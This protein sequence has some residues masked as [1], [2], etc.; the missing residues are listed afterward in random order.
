VA[1]AAAGVTRRPSLA[2]LRAGNHNNILSGPRVAL[3][4]WPFPSSSSSSSSSSFTAPAAKTRPLIQE[5]EE[6]GDEGDT[7][8]GG[9]ALLLK[10]R[11]GEV[12]SLQRQLAL[13]LAEKVREAPGVGGKGGRGARDKHVCLSFY[14]WFIYDLFFK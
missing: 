2:L 6:W 13:A 12:R 1:A 3:P 5:E 4:S 7:T 9:R 10:E 14:V 11:E 8:S